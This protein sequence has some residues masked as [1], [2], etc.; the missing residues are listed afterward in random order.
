MNRPFVFINVAMT[1]D[2]KI[3][4]VERRGRRFPRRATRSAST[5]C[6]PAQT[7]SMMCLFSEEA[8][9]RNGARIP[10]YQ[11]HKMGSLGI[12]VMNRQW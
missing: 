3:D 12:A 2:G 1:A 6:A 11:F 7:R 5:N 10:L 9:K 8:S 4:T